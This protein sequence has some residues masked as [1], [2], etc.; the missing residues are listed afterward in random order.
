MISAD[1]S[2]QVLSR[3][4]RSSKRLYRFSLTLVIGFH[5]AEL[6]EKQQCVPLC[7]ELEPHNSHILQRNGN[8]KVEFSIRV[9]LSGR[10][11]GI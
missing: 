10:N 6:K 3:E 4:L 7:L 1:T 8:V 9:N 2:V 5:E 11:Y